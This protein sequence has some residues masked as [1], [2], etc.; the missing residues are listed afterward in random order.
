M[1]S[2]INSAIVCITAGIDRMKVVVLVRKYYLYLCMWEQFMEL[3]Q[4][5][6]GS[7]GGG[8][9]GVRWGSESLSVQIFTI[10][11]QY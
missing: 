7:A 6:C 1:F 10:L 8:G 11:C 3:Y 9:G 2:R 5:Q 4:F